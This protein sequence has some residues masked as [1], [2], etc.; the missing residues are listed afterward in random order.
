MKS[1]FL[2]PLYRNPVRSP[3]DLKDKDWALVEAYFYPNDRRES[4]C[5]HPRRRIVDAIYCIVNTGAQWR[6][7]PNDFP[8][9][10]TVYD[11]FIR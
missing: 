4:G 2:V 3:S 11:P 8:P 5:K 9:W 10:K 1:R 6:Q 7:L